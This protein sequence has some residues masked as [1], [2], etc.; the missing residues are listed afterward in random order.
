MESAPPPPLVLTNPL[1]VRLESVVMFWEVLTV[2]VP[3]V[4]VK[5]VENV[6]ALCLL[7]NVFQSLEDKYPLPLEPAWVME[8]AGV[9]PPLE[10]IGAVPETLVTC[11]LLVTLPSPTSEAVTEIFPESAWPLT[12]VEVGTLAFNAFCKSVWA[13]RV[14]VIEPHDTPP[15]PVTQ[16]RFP[17]PSVCKNWP[18]VP[19]VVGRVNALPTFMMPAVTVAVVVKL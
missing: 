6:R 19:S 1:P 2:T 14:P 11:A 10:I 15:E 9:V 4:L 16:V 8:I 7:L 3:E 18:E 17:A 12:V 5:P 13:E